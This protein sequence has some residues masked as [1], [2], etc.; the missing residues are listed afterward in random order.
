MNWRIILPNILTSLNLLC[1]FAGIILS[2]EYALEWAAVCVLAAAIFDFLDGFVARAVKGYSE[3]GK[4]YDSLAD[5]ITFGVL[6]AIM[7]FQYISIAQGQY[8][9]GLLAR[10]NIEIVQALA[11]GLV[12]VFSAIRL[13]VFNVDA[14]QTDKFLGMPTPANALFISSFSLFFGFQLRHDFY[15][16]WSELSLMQVATVEKWSSLEFLIANHF[17]SPYFLLTLVV[18]CS[19]LLVVR[20][21]LIALKFKHFKVEGN[22]MR[23]LFLLSTVTLLLLTFFRIPSFPYFGFLV[24]PMVIFLYFVFS[25]A[26]LII[27]NK[28]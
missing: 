23:Y 20:L 8:G 21:P 4:Q 17:F 16:P 7:L 12:A 25:I 28:E 6:P 10:S 1:G 19:A 24:V 5:A 18:V 15:T 14:E 22:Q 27:A 11:G 3:F 26:D 9:N 2:F 13:G